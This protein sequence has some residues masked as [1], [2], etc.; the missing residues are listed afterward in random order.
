MIQACYCKRLY[1]VSGIGSHC[2]KTR[3]DGQKSV[4]PVGRLSGYSEPHLSVSRLTHAARVAACR[5][6]VL[7]RSLSR[8]HCAVLSGSIPVSHC[9][10]D[11]SLL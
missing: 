11:N 2:Y 9:V 3:R 8:G 4:L 10:H 6:Q 7:V 5:W 1:F